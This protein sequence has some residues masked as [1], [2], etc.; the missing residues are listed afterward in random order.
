MWYQPHLCGSPSSIKSLCM[1]YV[2]SSRQWIESQDCP[3]SGDRAAHRPET[4]RWLQGTYLSELCMVLLEGS[5]TLIRNTFLKWKLTLCM[6]LRPLKKDEHIGKKVK[7]LS[8]VWKAGFC[9]TSE[10]GWMSEKRHSDSHW[11]GSSASR[12]WLFLG[13]EGFLLYSFWEFLTPIFI[14]SFCMDVACTFACPCGA[15]C[16]Y[17]CA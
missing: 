1:L 11:Q 15:G 7:N 14:L 3:R 8:P 10:M 2:Q 17:M 9:A 5:K 13:F 16:I 12:Q 4:E 6:Q